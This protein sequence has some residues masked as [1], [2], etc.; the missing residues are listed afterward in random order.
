MWVLVHTASRQL[1]MLLVQV[2]LERQMWLLVVTMLPAASQ[3]L[4]IFDFG[5]Q[6]LLVVV[7][8][9]QVV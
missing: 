5:L 4:L 7:M 2:S 8:S 1:L 3:P 6:P 9:T